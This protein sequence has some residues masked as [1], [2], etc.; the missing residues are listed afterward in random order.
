MADLPYFL[1]PISEII[2]DAHW[3]GG[4]LPAGEEAEEGSLLDRI[5]VAEYSVGY[6]ADYLEA[7]IILAIF[8][9]L[10]VPM[11]LLEG[12]SLVIG[13]TS[14]NMMLFHGLLSIGE[15]P[16]LKP[17]DYGDDI[18]PAIIIPETEIGSDVAS[19]SPLVRVRIDISLFKLEFAR[20]LLTPVQIHPSGEIEDKPEG[21][22]HL[23][24]NG[25]L[26]T[27]SRGNIK[28]ILASD[29]ADSG[30]GATVSLRLS[31]SFRIGDT[32]FALT[33]G[34]V[35]LRFD[36]DAPT[37]SWSRERQIGLY[38]RD[39]S[40]HFSP[41]TLDIQLSSLGVRSLVIGDRGF[42][43]NIYALWGRPVLSED[44][45][46]FIATPNGSATIGRFF[47]A[48][49]ALGEL[50][51]SFRQNCITGAAFNANIILPFFDYPLGV[52]LSIDSDCKFILTISR[53]ELV[54]ESGD[55]GLVTLE[56]EGLLEFRINAFSVEIKEGVVFFSLNGML[57]PLLGGIDWPNFQIDKLGVNSR[58]EVMFE[59]GWINLPANFT[60]DLHGFKITL[61]Q[62][63]MGSEVKD[64]RDRQWIGLSGEV[65]LVEG[66]PIKGSVDGL[67]FSWLKD[68]AGEGLEVSLRGIAVE[69]SIPGTLQFSGS[70]NFDERTNLFKGHIRLNLIALRLE[71]EAQLMVGKFKD[72]EGREFG[73]FYIAL[74]A[75]LPTGIPLAATGTALYGVRGLFGVNVGPDKE[76]DESW[77]EW[78]KSGDSEEDLYSVTPVS[79]WNPMFDNFGF[80]AGITLGT[81]YDDG[82]TLNLN[83]MLVVLIPGPVILLEGKAN[84]LKQRSDNKAEEGALYLLAAL[85]GRAGTFQLNIDIRYS[86][87]DIV[88]VGGGLEAFFDFNNSENW[89]IWIGQKTPEN[90]RIRAEILALFTANLYFM[91]DSRSLMFGASVGLNINETYGPV[92][93]R[94]IARVS[95]D[96]A[97]FFKPFQLEGSLQFLLDINLTV[98]GIGLRLYLEALLSGQTPEPF[99]V[100]GKA[101]LIIGLFWPLPT[102]ECEVEF[103]WEKPAET[104]PTWPLFK[105]IGEASFTAPKPALPRI[106]VLQHH[107]S[108]DLR[109]DFLCVPEGT[110]PDRARIPVA[111][112]DSRP[113]LTFAKKLHYLGT[114]QITAEPDRPG[115]GEFWY[116]LDDLRLEVS[117][118]SISYS[119]VRHGINAA[120]TPNLPFFRINVNQDPNNGDD[121]FMNQVDAEEPVVELW[122]YHTWDRLHL[123]QR[124]TETSEN[125][126]C[127]RKPQPGHVGT[128]EWLTETLR[129]LPTEFIHQGL[130]FMTRPGPPNPQNPEAVR[131][132]FIGQVLWLQRNTTML[133]SQSLTVFFPEKCVRAIV[134]L[135]FDSEEIRVGGMQDDA[136][137][138]QIQAFLAGIPVGTN[139][140]PQYQNGLFV[141]SVNAPGGFD[142]LSINEQ[143]SPDNTF[144][145]YTIYYVTAPEFL[146]INTAARNTEGDDPT[147]ENGFMRQEPVLLPNKYYRLTVRTSVSGSKSVAENICLYFRTDD[148]PGIIHDPHGTVSKPYL[149]YATFTVTNTERIEAP[150]ST[151]EQPLLLAPQEYIGNPVNRFGSYLLGTYPVHGA[152]AHYRNEP[153]VI[154]FNERYLLKIFEDRPL[155]LRIRDRNGK[156]LAIPSEGLSVMLGI[157]LLYPGLMAWLSG[158]ESGGCTPSGGSPAQ[159]GIG[160]SFAASPDLRSNTL[161]FVEVTTTRSVGEQTVV[162]FDFQFT[163]SRYRSFNEHIRAIGTPAP[164]YRV[165]TATLATS[166]LNQPTFAANRM[167]YV[168]NLEQYETLLT[169]I[170]SEPTISHKQVVES[171]ENLKKLK[172][173]W[174][175]ESAILFDNLYAQMEPAF[176]VSVLLPDG[177][178]QEVD[179]RQRGLPE[180]PEMI[181]IS[182][183]DG[184][185]L[186]LWESPESLDWAGILGSVQGSTGPSEMVNFIANRDKTCALMM[187][188]SK[189]A[190]QN[191][192][193]TFSLNWQ[194]FNGFE[195]S[196]G[197]DEG[198]HLGEGRRADFSVVLNTTRS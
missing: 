181:A 37:P 28:F 103:S 29:V 180:K 148:G 146:P 123:Y 54:S 157:P 66:L 30:G 82:T 177:T 96:A 86:L 163:A 58:G 17:I 144:W 89:H 182:I 127:G 47:G 51:I 124:Q 38:V 162:V 149:P 121:Y 161:Y 160:L 106:A 196:I 60:L 164:V 145:L 15:P 90:K 4:V 63:G 75:Q 41:Q 187:C 76:K 188:G 165:G 93:L 105:A 131:P 170:A 120:G 153:I 16:I 102:I 73:V 34:E 14:T 147:R 61:S 133:R 24:L 12:L 104:F 83:A 85:D 5:F 21:N 135:F 129:Q 136:Q 195:S 26:Q 19:E 169:R 99:K 168:H 122:K 132:P 92:T 101:K 33:L 175:N 64:A 88:T 68:T 48:E 178:R 171:F 71:I 159:M 192:A 53:S 84:L 125:P 194:P 126:P 152:M 94:I 57:R 167:R 9:G 25:S 77:Y 36:A 154:G 143:G 111:P 189:L 42:S 55:S 112:V 156:Y 97:I 150:N 70:V 62:F 113:A 32:P 110:T 138:L 72:A 50:E 174:E 176:V 69:F 117:E 198:S 1:R 7:S 3:P 158:L 184:Q 166:Q 45:K 115:N 43:G 128:C 35:F 134:Y 78:Y 39:V 172:A 193:Y 114:Q 11:P 6:D 141:V 20:N 23:D 8:E 109:V 13:G 80:G 118:D 107:K 140:A 74:S 59:G 119:L 91:I 31:D 116:H 56:K 10:R 108:S 179:M 18:I 2:S 65:Q 49:I 87:Q 173:D 52:L 79:K 44:G 185:Q 183:A 27:D 100:Y 186:L 197:S 137:A 46:H 191:G 151:P 139:S 98:F 40:L 81:I 95:L 67:K 190:F 155:H 142:S 22:I 130:F